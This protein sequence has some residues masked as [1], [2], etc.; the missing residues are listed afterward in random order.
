MYGSFGFE[1]TWIRTVIISVYIQNY[2]AA[3]NGI[4][5]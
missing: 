2:T 1:V 4:P 5:A 3:A